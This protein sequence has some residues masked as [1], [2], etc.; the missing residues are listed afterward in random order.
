M[1]QSIELIGAP[2]ESAGVLTMVGLATLSTLGNA[3]NPREIAIKLIKYYNESK[4]SQSTTYPNAVPNLAGRLVE[5]GNKPDQLTAAIREDLTGVFSD[6]FQNV[7]IGVTSVDNGD[8]TFDVHI[9]GSFTS[10]GSEFRLDE[11][12]NKSTGAA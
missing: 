11:Q 5:Y 2:R 12:Y 3:K 10:G 9:T 4:P 8:G 7:D 6:L 1:E